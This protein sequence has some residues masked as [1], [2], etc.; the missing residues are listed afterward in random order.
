MWGCG[1]KPKRIKKSLWR[2]LLPL[3]ILHTTCGGGIEKLLSVYCSVSLWAEG[4]NVFSISSCLLMF[5]FRCLCVT[6]S[7]LNSHNRALPQDFQP[8][9]LTPA[10]TPPR[11]ESFLA[12]TLFSVTNIDNNKLA[13]FLDF[14]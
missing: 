10:D 12:T 8:L 7:F 2:L 4:A 14:L 13:V 11:W 1:T 5:C 6:V 3:P 9:L